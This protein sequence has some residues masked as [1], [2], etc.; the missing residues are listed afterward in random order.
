MLIKYTMMNEQTNTYKKM[1]QPKIVIHL[2]FLFIP[3]KHN[4]NLRVNLFP[5]PQQFQQNTEMT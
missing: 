2:I 3:Q 4:L 5:T 1:K